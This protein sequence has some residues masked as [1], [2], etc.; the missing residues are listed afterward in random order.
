MKKAEELLSMSGNKKAKTLV[1][2][3]LAVTLLLPCAIASYADSPDSNDSSKLQQSAHENFDKL[4]AEGKKDW[5]STR[6]QLRQSFDKMPHNVSKAQTDIKWLWDSCS[7][8][9][10]EIGTGFAKSGPDFLKAMDAIQS[11]FEKAG[12]KFKSH[13]TD[14]TQP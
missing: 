10:A 11:G 13:Q 4:S 7:G 8:A 1:G 14:Q 5:L 2:S 12:D 3:L 6:D 9:L